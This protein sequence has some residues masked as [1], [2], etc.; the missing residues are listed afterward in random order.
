[1][2]IALEIEGLSVSYADFQA[3][4]DINIKLPSGTITG[5]IGPNGAGKTSLIKAICGRIN[6]DQGQISIHGK[7]LSPH[8]SRTHLVGLVP[9]DIALYPFMTARENLA[10]FAR[11]LSIPKSEQANAV[12]QALSDVDMSAKAD[13]RIEHMSGGMKRRINVAAAIMHDPVVLI[14]DEPTAGVDTPA[15]DAIHGLVK[16][17]AAKGM[18]IILITHELDEVE[19]Y[20]DHVLLLSKGAVLAHATSSQILAH[21]FGETREIV[22]DFTQA[23]SPQHRQILQTFALR[24]GAVPTRW[25]LFTQISNDKYL[26]ELIKTTESLQPAV[27]D[28]SVRRPN[29][30]RLMEIVEKTGAFPI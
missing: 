19:H 23:P 24:E 10:V 7:P 22:V 5:L 18:T 12:D 25:Q 6:I 20:C 3:L 28:V 13:V 16:T 9:Q 21:A 8:S 29:L 30:T 2:T 14:L 15:R 4:N 17:L 26:T 1:M 27:R 11:Y